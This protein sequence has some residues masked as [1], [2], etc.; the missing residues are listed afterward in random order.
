MRFRDRVRS[1]GDLQQLS[2]F[3][4]RIYL[5]LVLSAVLPIVTAASNAST[6]SWVSI[7]VNVGAWIVFVIDLIVRMR[8]VR[9]YLR[10]AVGVFDLV[11]V[12][13]TAPWF[14]LPGFGGS[15][16]LVIARLARLARLLFVSKA[17]RRAA[18]RLGRVG[19]F[20]GGM[21]LFCSWMAYVAEHPTNPEFNSFGSALWWGVVTL[22]TVGYGDIVPDTQK[23]RIAGVFL[24]FTG[25]ATLGLI[26]ATLASLFRISSSGATESEVPAPPDPSTARPDA[27]ALAAEVAA[28]REQLT[29]LDRH[30]AALADVSGSSPTPSDG[31]G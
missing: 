20:S 4:Q 30:L 15:Q 18:Q 2:D 6:D 29:A 23:G 28:A 16:I 25:I 27:A 21:L 26:S 22:T 31:T 13:I 11:V 24:M 10:S 17:A 9:G 14:L 19:L 1:P 5:P 12:I 3:D 7:L 8:L